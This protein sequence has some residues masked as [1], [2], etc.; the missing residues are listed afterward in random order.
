MA[1]SW[2]QKTIVQN[3]QVG[4]SCMN[5]SVKRI[6][7]IQLMQW[8][9]AAKLIFARSIVQNN[10]IYATMLCDG[11]SKAFNAVND[12]N[13]YDDKITKEDYINHD[14]NRMWTAIDTL[15]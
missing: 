13:L 12:L 1:A 2:V 6:M 3:F 11:D 8:R 14:A 10:L 4:T 5:Q 7:K 15:K 9:Y